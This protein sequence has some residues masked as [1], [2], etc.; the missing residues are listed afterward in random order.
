LSVDFVE[1]SVEEV[2]E[3]QTRLITAEVGVES[4]LECV[5]RRDL[6]LVLVCGSNLLEAVPD[7]AHQLAG[8]EEML[9]DMLLHS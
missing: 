3:Y 6:V 4:E 1:F 9:E 7:Y 8:T 5:V 2:F